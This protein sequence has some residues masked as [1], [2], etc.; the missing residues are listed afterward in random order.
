THFGLGRRLK[1]D[2]LRVR[3]PN[4]VSQTVYYPG[5]EEDVLELQILKGSCPFLYAWDGH[6]FSFVTDVMWRSA[7]GMPLGIMA[8]GTDIA[9]APADAAREDLRD[10]GNA[11]APRDG[12]RVLELTQER[13]EAGCR[14]LR[15]PD[16]GSAPGARVP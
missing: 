5:T 6:A 13:W 3:W 11:V 12:R 14:A 7:L 16:A 10:S 8:G 4:G 15:P 2:V 9:A 1:A